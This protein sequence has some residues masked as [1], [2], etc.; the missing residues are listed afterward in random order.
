MKHYML[1]GI[2]R[3]WVYL[4]NCIFA[5]HILLGNIHEAC[6]EKFEAA[7]RNGISPTKYAMAV[8]LIQAKKSG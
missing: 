4:P 8:N 3:F 7:Q 1:P 6:T 2:T 5:K